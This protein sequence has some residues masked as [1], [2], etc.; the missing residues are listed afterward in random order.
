MADDPDFAA[1]GLLDGV[2][3]A[4]REARERL[5]RRLHDD[6]VA[7]EDLR[8]AAEEDRL[9]LI[10]VERALRGEAKYTGEEVAEKAGLDLAVMRTA[11]RATGI[12]VPPPGEQ[13]YT[14]NDVGQAERLKAIL[15]AGIPLD[16][17][18]EAN[19]V[20]GRG[21]AQ[22]AAAMRQ[23]VAAA[24]VNAGDSEDEAAERL[25]AAATALMPA[26]GPTLELLF[27]QHLLEVVRRDVIGAVELQSGDV[28]AAREMSVA[29]GDLVGFTRL[30]EEID[31]EDL[32]RIVGRLEELAEQVVEPPVTVVKTI[33]DAVM[34]VAPKPGDLVTRSLALV[35][36]A[37]AEGEDFPQLRV[38]VACG[39]VLERGGDWYGRAVNLASRVTSRAR[40]GSV[41]VTEV[42]RE[43][44]GHE[45]GL[46]FRSAG[47]K[48]LRGVGDSVPLY[49]VR[50]AGER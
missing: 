36:A 31:P 20:M 46:T 14:E 12:P 17:L 48:K 13:A 16:S 8:R 39:P 27:G 29:F 47:T 41:L 40:P 10:P 49:R 25:T 35:E 22:I 7:L 23:M 5:L 43:N 2:E 19:R 24:F 18:V 9:V 32:G 30:G 37:D 26:M 3:G 50:R 33:G 15:D 45:D 11:R 34:L 21:M 38:G 6:G 44:A 1:E 4:A 42:V 28:G